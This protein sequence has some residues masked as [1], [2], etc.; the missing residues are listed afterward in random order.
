MQL[1]PGFVWKTGL[2]LEKLAIRKLMAV[3]DLL[4]TLQ[5]MRREAGGKASPAPVERWNPAYCGGAEIVI[6][7]NGEWVHEGARMT[8]EALV[9]LFASV[10]RKDEDGETYLVT[11]AEK[12]RIRVEDAPFIAIRVDKIGAGREAAIAFTTNVGDVVAAGPDHPLWVREDPR[13]GAPSPYVRV[14][15]RLDAKLSRAVFY[16]LADAAEM[17]GD[18]LGVWSQ[19]MFFPLGAPA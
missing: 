16:E 4:E 5:T 19:G 3:I 11:P 15:G 6:R 13:S 9:R 17:H 14:R 10:L 2:C 18:Q 7:A 1:F 12:I 8:R